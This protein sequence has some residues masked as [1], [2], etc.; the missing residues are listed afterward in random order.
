V[1]NLSEVINAQTGLARGWK[2]GIVF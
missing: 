2:S 1:L